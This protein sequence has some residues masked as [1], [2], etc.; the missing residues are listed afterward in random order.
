MR[1]TKT[2]MYFN[3]DSKKYIYLIELNGKVCPHY[4]HDSHLSRQWIAYNVMLKDLN[5]VRGAFFE[6]KIKKYNPLVRLSLVHAAI[7]LYGRCFTKAEGRGVKLDGNVVFKTA[8]KQ[9]KKIHDR[10]ISLRNKYVAH[11]GDNQIEEECYTLNLN[12]DLADKKILSDTIHG[13]Q[14]ID[15][16]A[17]LDFYIETVEQVKLYLDIKLKEIG[18]N[19]KKECFDLDI[20]LVYEKSKTP[21]IKQFKYIDL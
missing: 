13:L 18:K 10:L 14:R 7:T 20:N 21:R 11:A 17:Y 1:P 12:P 16:D 3:E 2:L 15:Q 9:N 6:L 19:L 4:I 8:S 5:N